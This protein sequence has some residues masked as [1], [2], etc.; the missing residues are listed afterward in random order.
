MERSLEAVTLNRVCIS[1]WAKSAQ[2]SKVTSAGTSMAARSFNVTDSRSRAA[3]FVT[4]APAGP[5]S[6]AAGTAGEP[7]VA[8]T[9]S[10]PAPLPV[11]ASDS[12]SAGPFSEAD[13]SPGDDARVASGAFAGADSLLSA[14]DSGS[15]V[16]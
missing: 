9:P 5:F 3:F 12:G 7:P 16:S 13:A 15:V 4:D 2:L 11:A 10:L 8:P 1:A 14:S 6:E